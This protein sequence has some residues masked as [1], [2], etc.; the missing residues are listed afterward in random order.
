MINRK[1]TIKRRPI[2]LVTWIDRDDHLLFQKTCEF[3]SCVAGGLRNLFLCSSMPDEEIARLLYFADPDI[4]LIATITPCVE[5]LQKYGAKVVDID[6]VYSQ[7]GF[8][9]PRVG[10]SMLAA[11]K[12]IYEQEAR[13]VQRHESSLRLVYP[14]IA[15]YP[16]F[17]AGVFGRYP[18]LGHF[19]KV[20]YRRIYSELIGAPSIN[21][22]SQNYLSVVLRE[23]SLLFPATVTTYFQQWRREIPSEEV[24]FFLKAE[25]LEDLIHFWNLRAFGYDV[26]AIPEE[27]REILDLQQF[28]RQDP[29]APFEARYCLISKNSDKET[30]KLAG[31]LNLAVQSAKE[32][33]LK[34]DKI[35]WPDVKTDFEFDGHDLLV[36][37]STRD[38]ES[39]LASHVSIRPYGV[40]ADT[41]ELPQLEESNFTRLIILPGL[42]ISSILGNYV[43]VRSS[44]DGV[45]FY[46]DAETNR[47]QITLPIVE[48]LVRA[49]MS[50]HQFVIRRSGAGRNS[51]KLVK[52]LGRPWNFGRLAYK[53]LLELFNSRT[54]AFE[55]AKPAVHTKTRW[56]N[57]I[58]ARELQNLLFEI[59]SDDEK[60]S[61]HLTFLCSNNVL[62]AG[63]TLTCPDCDLDNWFPL[64]HGISDFEC[65]RCLKDFKFPVGEPPCNPWSYALKGVF[66][67]ADF[68]EGAYAVVATIR[69]IHLFQGSAPTWLPGLE[70][71]TN[72]DPVWQEIDLIMWCQQPHRRQPPQTVF[73]E[74]KSFNNFEPNDFKKAFGLLKEFPDTFLIFS[75]FR[76]TLRDG[77]RRQIE[78]LMN[79]GKT[80]RVIILT[81]R[82]LF[83]QDVFLSD[84]TDLQSKSVLDRDLFVLAHITQSRHLR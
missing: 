36:D 56:R 45:T 11:L 30:T 14:E 17:S 78:E 60:V 84:W 47:I 64:E 65:I 15:R 21:V 57:F 75:T 83:T 46:N 42:E 77:E 48:N 66:S 61:E 52:A 71:Q 9:Q 10:I 6:E 54:T 63:L 23:P 5:K 76:S 39:P 67:L 40:F 58:T 34:P 18:E 13:Y 80:N 2:R 35:I 43:R 59:N 22:E 50:Q 82:E 74:C 81:E 31:T 41:I 27:W 4:V 16:S 72:A 79:A 53:S 68:A 20:D 69:F 73:V 37:L 29:G 7:D 33:L 32:I 55:Q 24:L 26:I 1:M 25:S 70:Y 51:E 44:L 38:L 12:R 62:R 19:P 49:W 28:Q 3:Y 8:W